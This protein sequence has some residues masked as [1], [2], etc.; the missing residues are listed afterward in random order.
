M[1]IEVDPAATLQENPLVE[2]G[3]HNN[4][5]KI[6]FR[7]RRNGTLKFKNQLNPDPLTIAS[8]A[9]PPP[10]LVPGVAGPQAQFVVPAGQN[11]TVQVSGAYG[12]G[13]FFAY[14]SQVGNSA[15]E[16]PIVIVDRQ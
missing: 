6:V 15:P 14:T 1:A 10:F 9:I 2:L 11:L 4:V 8:A 5:T 13:Q 16:D 12:I 3:V 7:I